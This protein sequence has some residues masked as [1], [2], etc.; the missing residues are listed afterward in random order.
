ME[1]HDL[2]AKTADGPGDTESTTVV[3]Y[4]VSSEACLVVWGLHAAAE[5]WIVLAQHLGL[6]IGECAD[7]GDLPVGFERFSL[8]WRAI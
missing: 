8:V 5:Y 3:Q 6:L 4:T 1:E 2:P 7:Q